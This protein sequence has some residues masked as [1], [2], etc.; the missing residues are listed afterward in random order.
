MLDEA[1]HLTQAQ[2]KGV[3][4]YVNTQGEGNRTYM[5]LIMSKCNETGNM[6]KVHGIKSEKIVETFRLEDYKIVEVL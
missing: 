6:Q 5:F 3:V 2:F 1:T 4:Y